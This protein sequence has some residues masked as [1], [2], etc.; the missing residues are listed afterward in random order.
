MIDLCK[1][2]HTLNPTNTT[3]LANNNITL[4]RAIPPGKLFN[5]ITPPTSKEEYDRYCLVNQ[6]AI[7]PNLP[8]EKIITI[9]DHACI[10]L[11][12]KI[13]HVMGHGIPLGWYCRTDVATNVGLNKS[14][15]M[16]RAV[17][18]MR[19]S[20]NMQRS[21]KIGYLILFSDAFQKCFVRAK[22][23]GVWIMT[24]TI[25]PPDGTK[26]SIWHSH[27]IAVG[28]KQW[29]HL[30]VICAVMKELEQI[31]QGVWRY[32]AITKTMVH[33]MFDV[34]MYV[35]DR[36]ERN[37]VSSTIELGLY[38]KLWKYSTQYT[39][40]QMKSCPTCLAARVLW[41]R[42]YYQNNIISPLPSN[43]ACEHCRDWNRVGR[44]APFQSPVPENYPTSV[45][46]QSPPPPKRRRVTHPT[47]PMLPVKHDFDY[48]QT[49]CRY[50]YYN[51]AMGTWTQTQF[52]AYAQALGINTNMQTKLLHKAAHRNND[53]VTIDELNDLPMPAIYNHPSDIDVLIDSPMH[54]LFLGVVKAVIDAVRAYA[55]TKQ[56]K[57][58]FVMATEAPMETLRLFQLNYLR[59]TSFSTASNKKAAN[60]ITKLWLSDNYVAFERVSPYL[61]G[62]VIYQ[63]LPH[64]NDTADDVA[65]RNALAKMM[66]AMFVMI[67]HIMSPWD[68]HPSVIEQHVRFF[69]QSCVE[70]SLQVTEEDQKQFWE[71]K[72]NFV[73]L[74]NLSHQII[75]FGPIRLY[76]DG[77]YERHIQIIKPTLVCLRGT[78]GYFKT[79]MG[80]LLQDHLLDMFARKYKCDNNAENEDEWWKPVRTCRGN[81]AHVYPTILAAHQAHFCQKPMSGFYVPGND[82]F[83]IAVGTKQQHTYYHV[84]FDHDGFSPENIMGLFYQHCTIAERPFNEWTYTLA[85]TLQ[86]ATS[87]LF[88][89][90]PNKNCL[91]NS[92]AVVLPDW[93]IRRQGNIIGLPQ[94]PDEMM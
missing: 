34:I 62:I 81:T 92:Y 90:T 16:R 36:P 68:P 94:I 40:A 75:E 74:L 44:T 33:T 50:A 42:T 30:P 13:N 39:A 37:F 87:C 54:L 47:P 43:N 70:Y 11:N 84:D 77:D 57:T 32:C 29:D 41:L 17:Q 66:T 26:F 4:I 15:A 83:C 72:A 63:V 5:S 31:R 20:G 88:L 35:S 10:K 27:V 60:G 69:L 73:S 51:I 56:K 67:S 14:R 2:L 7:L 78:K 82:G 76:W 93:R 3:L 53:N 19:R 65:C 61:F 91:G 71:D 38:T 6:Q 9:A 86:H 28:K 85:Q 8:M 80:H 48:L 89:P 58:K 23:N 59:L 64:R 45:H 79:R 21:T 49:G 25:C 22:G 24:V 18:R 12:D 46:P 52:K 1:L 55:T